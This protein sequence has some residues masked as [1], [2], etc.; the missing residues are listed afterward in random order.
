M[1]NKKLISIV[2]NNVKKTAL[3]HLTV[4]KGLFVLA[5]QLIF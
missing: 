1:N 3:S 4:C 2:L 5:E